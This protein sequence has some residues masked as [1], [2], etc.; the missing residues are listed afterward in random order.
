MKKVVALLSTVCICLC[1]SLPVFA[2][3]PIISPISTPD[4]STGTGD[5]KSPKTG[6]EDIIIYTVGAVIV[7]A[8]VAAVAKKKMGS[9]R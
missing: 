5:N 9:E 6:E 3:D 4:N 1:M 8:G 7:L 2:K